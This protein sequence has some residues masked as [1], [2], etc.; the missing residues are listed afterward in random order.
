M[1]SSPFLM[2]GSTHLYTLFIILFSLPLLFSYFKRTENVIFFDTFFVL[3][4][5]TFELICFPY[6]IYYLHL[7]WQISLPL[8]FCDFSRVFLI[9]YILTKYTPFAGLGLFW[10]IGGCLIAFL[11]P[12]IQHGFPSIEYFL[13]F[14]S[15]IMIIYAIIYILASDGYHPDIQCLKRAVGIG[16]VSTW[17]V[18]MVNLAIGEPANYWYLMT[19]P[20]N[21]IAF[22]SLLPPPPFHMFLFYPIAL[23]IFPVIYW[24]FYVSKKYQQEKIRVVY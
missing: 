4:L 13:F 22:K 2:Y 7:P 23:I 10:G 24:P 19:L 15:H 14:S 21:A 16:I 9:L 11:S 20:Q 1:T 6:S 18:Y 17:V 5:V 8:N 3:G 12:D